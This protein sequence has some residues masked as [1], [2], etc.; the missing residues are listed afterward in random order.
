MKDVTQL[1]ATKNVAWRF[2][3][4]GI[5]CNAILPGSIDSAIGK[6][7]AEGEKETWD[8]SGYEEVA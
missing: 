2:R 3:N 7:I 6:A 4:E 5:R 1:G 8:A